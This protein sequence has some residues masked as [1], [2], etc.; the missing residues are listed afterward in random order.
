MLDQ[1]AA[2]GSP[3]WWLLRLGKRLQDDRPRL[4]RLHNY[5]CGQ[6]P[7]PFGNRKMRT[8]YRRFQKMART[9]FMALVAESLLERLK[10]VG[11]RAGSDATE[12]TDKRAWKWWQANDLDS[13]A[14]LVHR[15]AVV[16]GRAYVI[17][18]HDPDDPGQ[19]L[20][21]GEDPR[22]V[23]HESNPRNQRELVAVLKTWWDD[24]ELRH[25]AVLYLPGE[26]HYYQTP[27]TK[28][29][30]SDGT[31]W[32]PANWEAE[33]EPADTGSDDMPVVLFRN[34]P[35]LCGD[36][37]GEFED[38][39]DIQDRINM[40]V[41]DRMVIATMQAYRQRYATGVD[42]TDTEGRP[43]AAFDPGADLLWVVPDEHAKFGDFSA[44]DLAGVLNAVESD[45][46]Y[47][48]SVTRTP[49][50]YLLGKIANA[51]AEALNASETGLW[52]RAGERITEYSASWEQVY[53]QAGHIIDEEIPDDAEVMW[54]DPQ[55]RSLAEKAAASVQLV[56]AGV[57]WRTR[58]TLL[59]FS[60]QEID[61]MTVERV[62]DAM[63]AMSLAPQQPGV[64]EGRPSGS[65]P[66]DGRTPPQPNGAGQTFSMRNGPGSAQGRQAA[67][68]AARARAL[69]PS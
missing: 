14:G 44:V 52:S 40:Q 39:T 12:Q 58:M 7:L 13:V 62:Q 25:R 69:A 37:L 36:T 17:V 33:S 5:W 55:F 31:L 60:P 45:V 59:D 21:T 4:D 6:H 1:S 50:T 26:V 18:G 11:F 68:A 24:I 49:P 63:L 10:V 54:A 19:P 15:A 8:A 16:M 43:T 46:Q 48:A 57:P 65:G 56:A 61:R 42:V 38:V 27:P 41:L 22:Q 64:P 66:P 20:I 2:P 35:D 67:P 53:R 29:K 34:R 3:D 23:I 28:Q 9:N 32:Q 47:L 51:S 30:D